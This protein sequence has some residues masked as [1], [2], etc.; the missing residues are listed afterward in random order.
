MPA[1]HHKPNFENI[2]SSSTYPEL[3]KKLQYYL[4]LSK[5]KD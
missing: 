1:K 2:F 3:V 5:N 4:V